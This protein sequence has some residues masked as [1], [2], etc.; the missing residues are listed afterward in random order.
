[1]PD[2]IT[3][4]TNV[5]G[6][7][8]YG[9]D[10]NNDGISDVVFTTTSSS[11]FSPFGPGP[12]QSYIQQPG[13]GTS[14]LLRTD[15][16]AYFIEGA[17]DQI[18]FG[19]A[20]STFTVSD[21]YYAEVRIFDEDDNLLGTQTVVAD[22]TSTRFGNSF[23][24][25][26][27]IDITFS[28]VASYMELSFTSQFGAFI[29][30]NFEG[31]FTTSSAPADEIIVFG[32]GPYEGELTTQG[33]PGVDA[34]FGY[35]FAGTEIYAEFL[36][37]NNMTLE[38]A[39]AAGG[40]EYFNFMQ[41]VVEYPDG[42]PGDAP[43]IDPSQD[44][45]AS[46]PIEADDLPFYY[47][48]GADWADTE[49]YFENYRVTGIDRNDDTIVDVGFRFADQPYSPD[50]TADNPMSFMLI[51]VGVYSD[52]TYEALTTE[53]LLWHSTNNF[54][55]DGTTFSRVN[56]VD[57]GLDE[58]VLTGEAVSLADL[59]S[60]ILALLRET[61]LV[62]SGLNAPPV[63]NDDAFGVS[64]DNTLL[65]NVLD[66]NGNGA[67]SDPDGDA[68]T[69][70][71]VS[72]PAHGTLVLNADGT[73]SYEADADVFDLAL[74]G[75]VIEQTFNYQIDDGNGETDHATAT[76]TVAILDD[77]ETISAG[78]GKDD[79]VGTDG[80]EDLIEGGNGKDRL[81]GLDGAD[82]IFGGNGKDY[83]DGGESADQLFGGNGNDI[84]IG[85]Q[86]DDALTG[87]RG[88]DT[89]VFALGEGTDT[90]LDYE[91]GKDLIGLDGL[92]FGDLSIDQAGSDATI[93]AGGELLAIL[94]G[95]NAS[96]LS[97][98][99]FFDFV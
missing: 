41:V 9:F 54:F 46:P 8:S 80:G 93:S 84:L 37:G 15:M 94:T 77:G 62:G 24:P 17:T 1:M 7:T 78:N 38:E 89:F 87:G 82:R 33:L 70:S 63:A 45:S 68:L 81:F 6:E 20:L 76:I 49:F 19:F 99:D 11:A 85:G 58:T 18:N 69:V 83:L 88:N 61:G 4:S 47:D 14:S 13:L 57:D 52:G 55:G 71:L 53:A 66:D 36:V 30:D 60:D 34:T 72:G 95:V 98:A 27:E 12:N 97:E 23:F 31:E 28:G 39:A 44:G 74:P 5:F 42:S 48:V 29:I 64:E 86:G 26:G 67:D 92:A 75:D 21:S 2:L 40:F 10:G 50:A 51:P 43:Y 25:E 16:K 22:F 73:F 59:P 32:N 56:P 3:F 79:V 91:V 65:G 96:G 35:S 90:V